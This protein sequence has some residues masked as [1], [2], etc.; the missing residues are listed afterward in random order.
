MAPRDPQHTP[1]KRRALLRRAP[2]PAPV[3]EVSDSDLVERSRAGDELAYAELWR[4]H[5]RAGLTLSLI[6]I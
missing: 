6:H 1:H 4:R 2:R 3:D 5:S